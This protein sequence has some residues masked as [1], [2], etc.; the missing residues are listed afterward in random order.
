MGADFPLLNSETLNGTSIT[1]ILSSKHGIFQ[2]KS[3]VW[4]FYIY[5]DHLD[6]QLYIVSVW[7]NACSLFYGPLIEHNSFIDF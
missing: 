1:I 2:W 4:H 3:K 7:K 6:R 5:V